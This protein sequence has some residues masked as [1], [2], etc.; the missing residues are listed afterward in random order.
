MSSL[1]D[2]GGDSVSLA[3]LGDVPFTVVGIEKS[4]YDDKDGVIIKTK[5]V[6]E[7]EG[8]QYSKFHTTRMTIVKTLTRLEIL[9]DVNENNKPLGPVKCQEVQSKKSANKYFTLVDAVE[10]EPKPAT[11][12]KAVSV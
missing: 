12:A 3:K 8:V 9:A 10:P 11:A 4:A 6:F 2:Y 1:S 5:E 7:V